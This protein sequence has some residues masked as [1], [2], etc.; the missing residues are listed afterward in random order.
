MQY[1]LTSNGVKP[2]LSLTRDDFEKAHKRVAPHVY[3]TP[4]L[5]S[6]SLNEVTG[7]NIRLKAELFQKGGSYK[8]RGPT[9]L[10]GLL[11]EEERARGVICSSAGNHSQGVAIAA[12]KSCFLTFKKI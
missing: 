1:T 10:I 9:N 11:T 8:V 5:T 3:R 2:G 4:L 12:L 6:R 7:F